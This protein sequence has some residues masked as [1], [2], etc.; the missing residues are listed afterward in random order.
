MCSELVP[1]KSVDLRKVWPNEADNFTP[2]LAKP[3][4]LSWLGETL[5]MELADAE[6][7]VNVGQFRADIRC[8]DKNNNSV[9]VIENQFGESDHNHLGQLL[10]YAAGLGARTAIWIA[11]NFKDEHRDALNVI[12]KLDPGRL[13]I[14]GVEIRVGKIADSPRGVGF[15][16]VVGR[17]IWF[18]FHQYLIE[19]NS[20]IKN[21]LFRSESDSK[22]HGV[23]FEPSRRP[24]F[25]MA[26]W[27]GTSDR[28]PQ[29]AAN[30]HMSQS[31]SSEDFNRLKTQ[32]DGIDSDFGGQLRWQSHRKSVG[33]YKDI[34]NLSDRGDWPNQFEW[35]CSSLEKLDEVFGPL[36][37]G[38][39]HGNTQTEPN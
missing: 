14:F 39:T 20:S 30:L 35:L 10:T 5:N 18:E 32:L 1:L 37:N 21:R 17:D 9:V 26:A 13:K 27:R 2:W 12:N 4:H 36:I 34:A 25:W 16:V 31:K 6:C 11:A 22:Y 15:N 38:E 19:R 24:E 3:K 7:E 8:L 23:D 33:L 28:R 29:I